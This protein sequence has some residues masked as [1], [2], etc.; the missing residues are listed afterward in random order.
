MRK[1]PIKGVGNDIIE[2]KRIRKTITRYGMHF[3]KKILTERELTY[4]LNH[5][6]PAI[7][8]AGRFSAKEAIA[9]A[10]GTGFGTFL[11]F[12]DIE[13]LNNKMG[14]PYP[15]FSDS[16]NKTFNTPH[17]VLSISHCKEY[18]TTIAIISH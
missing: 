10:I 18:A 2:I 9:K 4:C 11:S 7:P 16:F 13:I 1:S 14:R 8:V 15:K 3:Y 17:I 6:D 12:R 5:I